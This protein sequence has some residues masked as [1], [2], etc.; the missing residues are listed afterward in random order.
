MLHLI[1]KSSQI[2][3]TLILNHYG[4]VKKQAEV[5]SFA[6]AN[7]NSWFM[8]LILS[9]STLMPNAHTLLLYTT[10]SRLLT[11]YRDLDSSL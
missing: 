5:E 9:I 4:N 2:Q 6:N 8:L 1:K 7:L 11:K 3:A 10:D